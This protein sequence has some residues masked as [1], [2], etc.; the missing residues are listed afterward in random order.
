MKTAILG[1]VLAAMM[2]AIVMLPAADNMLPR[3]TDLQALGLQSKSQNLPIML[4]VSQHGCSYCELLKSELLRPM[5]ISGDYTDQVIMAE[6]LIDRNDAIVDFDGRPVKGRDVAMR[7]R[8]NLTPTLLFLDD[9]GEQLHPRMVGVKT[10]EMY[11][12]YVDESISA[13]RKRLSGSQ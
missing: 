6:L 7:Y 9:K 10:I 8:S 2:L 4:M 5:L 3:A 13:A 11:S 12:Y 1:F